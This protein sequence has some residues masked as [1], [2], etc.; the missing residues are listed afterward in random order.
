MGGTSMATPLTAGAVGLIR[1]FLRKKK[2]IA[3]PSAALLKATLIAGA[4][5]LSKTAPSGVVLDPHQGFGR[6][7]LDR[8]LKRP[9]Y[10]ADE[11]ALKTGEQSSTTISVPSRGGHLRI[12]MCYSDFPGDT[13]INNLNLIVTDPSGKRY[14]GNQKTTAGADLALDSTNNVEVVDVPKAGS[15][16]WTINVIAGNVPSGP[17]DFALV[18][19]L[20]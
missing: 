14:V 2:G 7:N 5:R 6:V 11:S 9:L 19:V 15:G 18:A 4:Q 16:K 13:L 3:Q 1:E 12:V 10:L 20:V 8:S 17:Q